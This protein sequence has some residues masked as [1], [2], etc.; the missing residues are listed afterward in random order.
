MF[1]QV[2][3]LCLE[4]C[5]GMGVHRPWG[6][7]LQAQHR[8]AGLSPRALQPGVC[9]TNLPVSSG[10]PGPL[11]LLGPLP[12]HRAQAPPP[13]SLCP[14]WVK[15]PGWGPGGV[16][17][18]KA[19]PGARCRNCQGEGHPRGDPA[20]GCRSPRERRMLEVRGRLVPRGIKRCEHLEDKG[21]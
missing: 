12:P 1:Y 5:P 6:H 2:P 11:L 10:A 20:C 21:T 15:T 19:W 9:V 7:S 4:F 16:L 8:A 18:T 13:I 17:G 14:Q 3:G